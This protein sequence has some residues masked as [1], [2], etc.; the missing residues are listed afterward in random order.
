MPDVPHF[1]DPEHWRQLAEE[2][3]VLAEQMKDEKARKMML[4][5]A[6]DYVELA[7]R[8]AIRAAEETKES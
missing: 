7:V 4:R 1:N 2:C 5:I 3:R 6:D 8:A